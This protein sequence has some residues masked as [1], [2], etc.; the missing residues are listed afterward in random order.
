MS[1]SGQSKIISVNLTTSAGIYA[2]GD[3]IDSVK[4]ITNAVQNTEGAA[5]LHSVVVID[6]ANQKSKIDL[7]FFDTAPTVG[8]DNAANA[9][10]SADL[11]NCLGRI[12]VL[13]TDYVTAN[14]N[15]EATIRGLALILQSLAT[16]KDIYMVA[17]SRGTPTYASAAVNVVVK[18][19]LIQD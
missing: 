5:M 12:S 7:L 3:V 8:A 11:A 4:T 17:V 19:G 14:S 2:A 10:S 6:K 1:M 16:K 15:A 9:I 18:L 13:D